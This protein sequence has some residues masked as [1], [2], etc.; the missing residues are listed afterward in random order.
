MA[1]NTKQL[2]VLIGVLAIFVIVFILFIL[3]SGN[4]TKDTPDDVATE[5][6]IF[7]LEDVKTI[8]F[9]NSNG[10]FSF[11]LEGDTWYSVEFPDYTINQTK[12]NNIADE[13]KRIQKRICN[14]KSRRCCK[15]TGFRRL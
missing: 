14:A 13:I 15:N 10:T 9:T 7:D 6:P 1:K 2:F 4:N 3:F 5:K 8:S 11:T 12:L